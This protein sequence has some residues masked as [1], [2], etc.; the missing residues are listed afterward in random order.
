MISPF[1][2]NSSFLRLKPLSISSTL[3]LNVQYV[4][5]SI[6][7]SLSPIPPTF[8][9]ISPSLSLSLLPLFPLKS[10][11]M[12]GKRGE[13]S[14]VSFNSIHLELQLISWG[15]GGTEHC[16]SSFRPIYSTLAYADVFIHTVYESISPTNMRNQMPAKSAK[17]GCKFIKCVIKVFSA[18]AAQLWHRLHK[19][20]TSKLFTSFVGIIIRL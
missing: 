4:D 17:F 14:V 6:L 3:S 16:I 5:P 11:W 19:T 9:L 8:L 18:K 13:G 12:F 20:N 15:K 10:N 7:I 2:K 1:D